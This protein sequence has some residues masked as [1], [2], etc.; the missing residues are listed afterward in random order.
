MRCAPIEL[1]TGTLLESESVLGAP[2]AVQ[3]RMD[4][5]VEFDPTIRRWDTLASHATHRRT[6]QPVAVAE[7]R[8]WQSDPDLNIEGELPFQRCLESGLVPTDGDPG[9]I[10]FHPCGEDIRRTGELAPPER[11]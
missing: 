1:R 3:L 11:P 9:I 6:S 8:F 2:G 4:D 7:Q 10:E 5:D